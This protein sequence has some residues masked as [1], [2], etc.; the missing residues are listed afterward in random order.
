M[1]WKENDRRK[2]NP[3]K[4]PGDILTYNQL[5][6]QNQLYQFLARIS[7]T[8]DKDRRDLLLLDPLPTV[9]EAYASIRREIM[10]HGIMKKEPSSDLESLGTG[11]VFAVKG[12]TYRREDDKSHLKCTHCGGTRHTKN[13]CFKLV[14]YPEWWPDTKKKGAKEPARFSDHNRTGRAAVGW[15]TD[16]HS[17]IEEGKNQGADM[18]ITS[19]KER[20]GD[21]L[22]NGAQEQ[23]KIGLRGVGCEN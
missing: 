23:K 11:G 7:E 10:R 14:G 6:Q 17:F 12:R 13:E 21:L 18:N 5:I 4:Y 16:E 20:E 9:E 15:S 2:P 8:F 3:M 22:S 19:I 1:L